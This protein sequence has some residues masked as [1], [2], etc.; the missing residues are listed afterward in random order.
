[1]KK[2]FLPLF[3]FLSLVISVANIPVSNET[4][5][6][7]GIAVEKTSV[8]KTK[9][10]NTQ[11]IVEEPETPVD[12]EPAKQQAPTVQPQKQTVAQKPVAAKPAQKPAAT[13]APKAQAP[14]KTQPAQNILTVPGIGKSI[15]GAN[16]SDLSKLNAQVNRIESSLL[17][18]FTS[19]G[20]SI[21]VTGEN[22]AKT[23]FG[24]KYSSV[25]GVTVYGSRAI[26]IEK[27]D[28]AIRE[29]TIHEFGHYL[30]YSKG[31]ISNKEA[32]KAIYN[33]EVATFRS[34]IINPG[35]V[36]DP[37]EF[38]AEMFFYMH[39]N[40]S[41]CTPKAKAFISQLY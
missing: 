41:K 25:Q 1:M 23:H 39:T 11:K 12:V 9:R 29:S 16:N 40:P 30:D 36:R 24:G 7:A 38:F 37:Q 20:W 35:C 5:H 21:Y 2:R 32:F 15:N 31:F 19:S 4:K 27:R 13:Q 17:N 34:R 33:E 8:Q 18:K 22:L 3:I 26:Y 28:V 6:A 10:P 14:A